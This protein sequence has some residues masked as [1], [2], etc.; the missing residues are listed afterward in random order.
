VRGASV[1]VEGAEV[2]A[3]TDARGRYRIADVEP[4]ASLVVLADGY[5]AALGTAAAAVDDIVLLAEAQTAETIEVVGERAPEAQGAASLSREQ[6]QRLPG[7]ANDV[8]R[9]ITAMP[10]VASH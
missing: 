10:G 2:T 1:S 5:G 9:A 4:G 3:T 8:L 7:A 6:L